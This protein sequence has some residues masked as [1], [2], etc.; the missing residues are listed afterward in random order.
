VSDED[1]LKATISAFQAGTG[2]VAID[3]E[4]ASG[5][6]YSQRAYL[7]QL[8]REGVGTALI[9]P[10]GVP[11]LSDLGAVLADTEWV[12]H[13]AS[14]DLPC[15]DEVGMRPTSLFDTELAA[16]LLGKPKVGLGTLVEEILGFTLEKGHSAADWSTRPLPEDWLRYAALD[17][18]LLLELREAL[19]A[20]LREA[21]KLQWAY[22]EFEAVRTAG[23]R[24]PRVEPWRRTSGLHRVRDRRKLAAVRSLW[25]A[26]DDLA[27]RRDVAPTRVLPDAAIIDAVLAAP[28]TKAGLLALAVYRG[29]SQRREADRWFQAL[30][31]ARQVPDDELPAMTAVHDGPP[32]ART[33]ASREPDA[34]DR[35]A[36]ARAAVA[37]VGEANNV[38]VENLLTPDSLR[39]V[40]W[41]PPRPPTA[42]AVADALRERGARDWQ[43]ALTAEV[44]A[45]AI[46]AP[47]ASE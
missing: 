43:V 29:R 35:L 13:A 41:D 27:Q 22:E 38:P 36:A 24:E 3:A 37:E 30:D 15:L 18:E 9:D 4:R 40:V 16:R 33:W 20:E 32:P 42:E 7:V 44:V 25:E 46:S 6:R 10:R 14:Q 1:A 23:P 47:P 5:Y 34:A 11:D 26:R 17:V 28:R 12:L 31:E 21:E 8:R 2:A 45:D 19:E 39:R